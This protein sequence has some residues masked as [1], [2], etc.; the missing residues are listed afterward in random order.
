MSVRLQ[1]YDSTMCFTCSHFAAHRENVV[2]RNADFH[3]IV[4][5]TGFNI[6]EAAVQECIK[7]GSLSQWAQGGVIGLMDHDFV[8]WIGDLNYRIDETLGTDEVFEKAN[9]GDLK[10]LLT[11][12]QLNIER[13]N[14]NVFKQFSE[15]PID[16]LPTYKYQ[17]GT[18]LYEVS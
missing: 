12:D 17:P 18:D 2:G 5:K 9:N 11:H 15:G 14:G 13:A 6:G 4:T 7:S 1:I 16:F 10:S 3:S 8:F